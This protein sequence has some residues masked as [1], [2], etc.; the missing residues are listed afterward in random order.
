MLRKTMLSLLV[1]LVCAFPLLAQAGDGAWKLRGRVI[2]IAP[3]DDSGTILDTGTGV[4]VDSATTLEVDVTYMF[5]ESWGLEVIAALA[6]HDIKTA[7]GDLAGADAGTVDVLPPTFTV[8]Y[9]FDTAGKAHPYLGVG[10]NFTEF[11]SYDLSA[12]LQALG[13]TDIDFDSSFGFAANAGV[14]I[15]LGDSWLLNFD[16][17]YITIGTDAELQTADG[18]LTTIDVDIDPFV[19]GAGFGYRF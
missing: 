10:V 9:F 14:D 16:V 3:N 7:G 15:D 18:P 8:Q 19:F 11:P 12:D 17:K 5:N 4:E 13:V 6:S 2:N 1:I